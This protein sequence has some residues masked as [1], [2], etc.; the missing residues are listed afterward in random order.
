MQKTVAF[1]KFLQHG[2][3]EKMNVPNKQSFVISTRAVFTKFEQQIG[4]RIVVKLKTDLAVLDDLII[5][6]QV[7]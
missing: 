2:G 3:L 6:N 5:I 7:T 1:T 4:H